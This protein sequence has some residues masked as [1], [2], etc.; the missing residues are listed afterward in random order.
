MLYMHKHFNCKH[1]LRLLINKYY[2]SLFLE[3]IYEVE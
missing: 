1:Y 3:E 2:S